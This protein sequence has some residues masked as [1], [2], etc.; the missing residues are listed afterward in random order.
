[1]KTLEKAAGFTHWLDL[2]LSNSF[3]Q[4]L[5]GERTSNILS[6]ATPWG[7]KRPK[8]LPEG[9]APAS[10]LL[11]RAVMQIFDEFDDF[12]ICIFD[13]I[14]LLCNGIDDGIEKFRKVISKCSKH[15]VV[16]KFA[17]SW[18]GFQE[19]KF[20]GEVGMNW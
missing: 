7:L 2:D 1:M 10:G 9:V 6:V 3:H 17:K 13:N 8:Y 14:L 5:L 16:L 15:K 18:I 20:F 19:C 11:Q 12:C 4:L